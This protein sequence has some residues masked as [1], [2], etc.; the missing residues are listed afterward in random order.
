MMM[1][2]I[3]YDNEDGGIPCTDWYV[4]EMVWNIMHGVDLES[5]KATSLEK[6]VRHFKNSDL[7]FFVVFAPGS[8]PRVVRTA[9]RPICS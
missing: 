5:A 4:Q 6:R 7:H 8:L 2:M 9:G 1:I 3:V